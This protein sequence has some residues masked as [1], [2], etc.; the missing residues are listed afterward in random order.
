MRAPYLPPEQKLAV[1]SLALIVVS[2][3]VLATLRWFDRAVN[4]AVTFRSVTS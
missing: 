2:G 1:A 3:A 4:E